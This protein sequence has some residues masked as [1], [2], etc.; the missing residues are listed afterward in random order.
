[1]SDE[2]RRIVTEQVAMLRHDLTRAAPTN[3]QTT[4]EALASRAVEHA[5]TMSHTLEGVR[6]EVAALA[7]APAA[8]GRLTRQQLE[9]GLPN[10]HA[11]ELRAALTPLSS[12]SSLP[13]RQDLRFWWKKVEAA[14]VGMGPDCAPHRLGD[15]HIQEVAP[16]IL[17]DPAWSVLSGRRF[18]DWSDFKEMVN[19][20][21]G[22]TRRQCLAAF[23]DMKPA[24]SE[25]TAGFLRRVEDMR[26]RYYV[27]EEET[28]RHF[29]RKLRE[30]DLQK[31]DE[32][33][34]IC[35]LLG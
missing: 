13:S 14:L 8:S 20:R 12:G 9:E 21:F 30:A 34:D 32:L 26:A 33:S 25:S 18:G 24:E 5:R 15:G 2:I 4:T 10:R 22:L 27:D 17:G 16:I 29:V 31:L 11:K 7:Q 1:M 35:A 19:G 23:F 6:D 28:R 3:P